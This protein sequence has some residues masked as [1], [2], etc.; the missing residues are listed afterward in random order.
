MAEH[1]I[2]TAEQVRRDIDKQRKGQT[3]QPRK[4]SISKVTEEFRREQQKLEYYE[5][6][7]DDVMS[8]IRN[9]GLSY[10]DIHARFG[11]HP[12]TLK[13]WDE[14]EIHKPQVGKMQSALRAC[15]ASDIGIIHHRRR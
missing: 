2:K 10:E 12:S 9:S 4:K 11:P 6:L 1:E 14:K 5:D 3:K 13:K 7:R 8:V 15:S